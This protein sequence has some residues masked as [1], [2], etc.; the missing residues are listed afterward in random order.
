[1]QEKTNSEVLENVLKM[2]AIYFPKIG[3][4]QGLN[5]LAGYLIMLGFTEK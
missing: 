2:L 3:Y 5:Y 1:M 4:T